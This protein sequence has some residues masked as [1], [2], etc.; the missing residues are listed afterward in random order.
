MVWP[1]LT[2]MFSLRRG[3]SRVLKDEYEFI[4]QM[5]EERGHLRNRAERE[6]RPEPQNSQCVMRW[7]ESM[8]RIGLR[9][10]MTW[11]RSPR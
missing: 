9:Y 6:R 5:W 2:G 3:A 7:H 8:T 1:S 10:W 11:N 4:T